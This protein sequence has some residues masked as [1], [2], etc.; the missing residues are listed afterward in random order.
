MKYCPLCF[1]PLKGDQAFHTECGVAML[2][3]YLVTTYHYVIPM[4]IDG[5]YLEIPQMEMVSERYYHFK[6]N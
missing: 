4:E 1:L 5:I 6:N 2:P 3:M